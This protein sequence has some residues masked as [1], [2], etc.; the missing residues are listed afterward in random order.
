M[1]EAQRRRD[2]VPGKRSS[3]KPRRARGGGAGDGPYG[4]ID[5]PGR[6]PVEDG[7]HFGSET[8]DESEKTGV[9]HGPAVLSQMP[10]PSYRS[11]STSSSTLRSESGQF[12]DG[13]DTADG[14]EGEEE[15]ELLKGRRRTGAGG[16]GGLYS[17]WWAIVGEENVDDA[18]DDAAVALG[19][20]TKESPASAAAAGRRRDA[21]GPGG[22]ASS[23]R[24]EAA[25]AVATAARSGGYTLRVRVTT[26][27]LASRELVA[28]LRA[29]L[30][31][32]RAA[33]E[34]LANAEAVVAEADARVDAA[35]A[36][37]RA[38]RE[39]N[40]ALLHELQDLERLA[41]ASGASKDVLVRQM[42][43]ALKRAERQLQV[44]AQQATVDAA[45]SE[46]EP[47]AP[48]AP[49]AGRPAGGERRA[50]LPRGGRPREPAATVP[51][52]GSGRHG[53]AARA[54]AKKG[55]RRG[56]RDARRAPDAQ[57]GEGGR[58]RVAQLADACSNDGLEVV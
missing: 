18:V 10:A 30:E 22:R 52:A 28:E 44:L 58:A 53:T 25:E 39:R 45:R 13:D 15:A 4:E 9:I 8:V 37:A 2:E 46:G 51:S 26:P 36:E 41:R 19:Y 40:D 34:R 48:S 38:L 16:S 57:E 42:E 54:E 17:L 49:P 24:Y 1:V 35:A 43:A 55:G 23:E 5:S 12:S 56:A 3:S 11:S 6:R 32:E 29:A 33:R 7:A 20:A 27:D 21:D 47:A 31:D 50:G 14:E